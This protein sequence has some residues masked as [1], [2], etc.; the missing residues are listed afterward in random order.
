M[1]A[2]RVGERRPGLGR[3]DRPI[4]A[5]GRLTQH[6]PV[7]RTF[8]ARVVLTSIFGR[9]PPIPLM[10]PTSAG[11]AALLDWRRSRQQQGDHRLSRVVCS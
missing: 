8:G 4:P 6:R 2:R 5:R 10:R 1:S 11:G 7:A 9:L 3:P